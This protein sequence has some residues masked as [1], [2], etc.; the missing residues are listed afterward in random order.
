MVREPAKRGWINGQFFPDPLGE[1]KV[2]EEPQEGQ[3]YTIACDFAVSGDYTSAGILNHKTAE[4]VATYRGRKD[5][6][7]LAGD[8]AYMGHHYKD[9]LL[10][11]EANSMGLALVN[12]LVLTG[13]PN[14]YKRGTVDTE[15]R[16]ETDK[17]GFLTTMATRPLMLGEL[18]AMVKERSLKIYDRD[19]ISEMMSFVVNEKTGR[20]EAAVGKHDDRVIMAALLSRSIQEI[21]P[22]NQYDDENKN[23]FGQ[24]YE[25]INNP[26]FWPQTKDKKWGFS[27]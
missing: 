19:I 8:L 23:R 1:W 22:V 18:Q 15:S 5:V 13:Y 17:L 16:T 9:A 2:W 25:N 11:P 7:D 12:A 20:P 6:N 26:E 21:A 14:I 10:M 27:G 4:I 24:N 3:H